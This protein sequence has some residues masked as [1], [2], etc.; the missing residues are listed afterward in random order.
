MSLHYAGRPWEIFD[1]LNRYILV[2]FMRAPSKLKPGKRKIMPVVY[3]ES[4]SIR[5]HCY[6]ARS[7][8]KSIDKHRCHPCA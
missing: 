8:L 6:A 2:T 1:V 3:S 5:V 7:M 4:M